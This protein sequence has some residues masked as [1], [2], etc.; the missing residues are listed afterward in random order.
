MNIPD[1]VSFMSL[2]DELERRMDVDARLGDKTSYTHRLDDGDCSCVG[3]RRD[4][5][6]THNELT[7]KLCPD[8]VVRHVD[9][10]VFV[11]EDG[12]LQWSGCDCIACKI[13]LRNF[14]IEITGKKAS[15]VPHPFDDMTVSGLYA[16]HTPY[17]ER[18]AKGLYNL[19][20]SLPYPESMESL[21]EEQIAETAEIRAEIYKAPTL[22][23]G[24][25]RKMAK[26]DSDTESC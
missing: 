15:E 16:R 9:A 5:M 20:A 8:A 25:K 4:R 19:D 1:K 23:R 13:Q 11:D 22:S 14:E 26:K 12:K 21:T 18:D 10:N 3:C 6:G 7:T 24:M 2:K 17:A